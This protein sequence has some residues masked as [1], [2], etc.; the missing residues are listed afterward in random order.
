MPESYATSVNQGDNV[1]VLFPDANDS[2]STKVSFAAKVI[3]PASRS[4]GVEIKL[5]RIKNLRPNMTAI[6]KIA[7]YS[8]GNTIVIP[9]KAIQRSEAGDYVF[10]DKDGL[11]SKKV[12]KVGASYGGQSEILSGLN[13]GDQL[14]TDGASDIEDGDK[15][16]VLA[17][18]K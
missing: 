10:V 14:V 9:M 15:I 12:V 8:K 1:L 16:R 6:L 3:D 17:S 18:T 7:D 13:V 2:L 11:A 5:P 4:F